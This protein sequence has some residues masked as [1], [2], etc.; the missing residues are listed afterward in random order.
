MGLCAGI[1]SSNTGLP[2]P[3][4]LCAGITSSIVSGAREGPGPCCR[5]MKFVNMWPSCCLNKFIKCAV[6]WGAAGHC[7]ILRS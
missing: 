2:L 3:V 1:T 4:E 5:L 6:G 7:E